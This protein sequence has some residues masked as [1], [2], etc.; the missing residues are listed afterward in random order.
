LKTLKE[1]P[2]NSAKYE[3][4]LSFVIF[5]TSILNSN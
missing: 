5:K 1:D 4:F 2:S 3:G